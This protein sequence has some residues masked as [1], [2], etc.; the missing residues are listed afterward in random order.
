M[1]DL[2]ETDGFIDLEGAVR[3]STLSLST[4]KRLI[5][6]GKLIVYRPTPGRTVLSLRKLREFI[7]ASAQPAQA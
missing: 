6:E 3:F 1:S 4:L 2:N 5:R 7:E